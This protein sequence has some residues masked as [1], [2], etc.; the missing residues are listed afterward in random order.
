MFSNT[1][2]QR[3]PDSVR[4]LSM[5]TKFVVIKHTCLICWVLHVGNEALL[6]IALTT[7]KGIF[8]F[9]LKSPW[10]LW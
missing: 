6:T 10:E 4:Y 2:L 1:V 9:I 3:R 7:R 5:L 8:L